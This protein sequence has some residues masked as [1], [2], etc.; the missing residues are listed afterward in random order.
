M[1]K[2]LKKEYMMHECS[3]CGRIHR[4]KNKWWESK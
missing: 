3:D 2:K 1:T 4:I